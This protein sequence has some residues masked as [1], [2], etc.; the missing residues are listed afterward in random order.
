MPTKPKLPKLLKALLALHGVC[1]AFLLLYSLLL[2]A[3]SI[4]TSGVTDFVS[5]TLRDAYWSS[6]F[7]FSGFLLATSYIIFTCSL[8]RRRKSSIP[9][10]FIIAASEL[11]TIISW[12]GF[13]WEN[14]SYISLS[15]WITFWSIAVL[16][17]FAAAVILSCFSIKPLKSHLEAQP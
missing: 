7:K 11:G 4:W 15:F 2:V 9:A 10:V 1:A 14:R 17:P 12:T 6:I 3:V 13:C 8:F 16:L 5:P